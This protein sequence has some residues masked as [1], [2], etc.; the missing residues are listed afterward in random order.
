MNRNIRILFDSLKDGLLIVAP[1]GEVQFANVAA[2]ALVPIVIGKQLSGEWLR[3][4]LMAIQ[5]GYLKPPLTFDITVPGQIDAADRMRVT[6]LPS[7]IGQDFV[8]LMKNVTTEQRYENVIGNL[9]EM[10][11][12][13]ISQPTQQFLDAA[14]QLLGQFKESAGG[15]WA[16][17]D[18]VAEVERRAGVVARRL[19]QIGLLASAFKTAP[20]RGEDRIVVSELIIE[21]VAT[22]KALLLKRQIGLSYAG[23]LDGLPVIYGSRTFLVHAI[24][25]YLRHLVK[26][27]D[28]GAN[29]LISM[30]AK[31]NFMLLGITS[32][33]QCAIPGP[34]ARPFMP[35]LEYASGGN[36]GGLNLT[37]PLCKRVVEINGGHLRLEKDGESVNRIVF[38]LPIGAPAADVRD[39]GLK[40]A[41][42]Y[43]QDLLTLMQRGNTAQRASK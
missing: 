17:R 41:E 37:L 32:F 4:Q 5:R 25:G 15:D 9:A 43:A 18:A 30:R 23:L 11:D 31:G 24:A 35:L 6:I 12:C 8:V 14:A 40:Q 13:E 3:T 19:K 36:A 27:S 21:V 2:R 38:E 16:L 10:L 1:G 28:P 22:V 42:R 20:I 29:I 34:G 7:P 26:Q 39:L 33:G